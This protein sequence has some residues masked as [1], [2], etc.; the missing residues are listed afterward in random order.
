MSKLKLFS[1]F[2]IFMPPWLR[3]KRSICPSPSRTLAADPRWALV[4]LTFLN[5]SRRIP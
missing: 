3:R 2:M 4:C 1:I 5:P